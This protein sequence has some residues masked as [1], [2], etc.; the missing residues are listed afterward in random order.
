MP[1]AKTT[2]RFFIPIVK[3]L[4]SASPLIDLG[5]RLWV[6]NVFFKS[7]LASLHDWETTVDLFKYEYHVPLLSPSV[8]AVLGT[9]AELIFPVLLVI[10]LAGRFSAG[11]LFIFNIIAV[12][13][14]PT[15]GEAGLKDH[16]YWGILLLVT[17]LHG[18][19]KISIDHLI[20]HKW[21]W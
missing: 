15:L 14:Y 17:L 12:I 8:A 18:P 9:G 3:G 7:G 5:V 2:A 11:A 21:M 10:G 20:R 4:D 13:S 16:A 6:A 19:G 1:T